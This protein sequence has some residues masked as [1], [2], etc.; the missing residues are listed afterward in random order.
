MDAAVRIEPKS[1]ERHLFRAYI[2][3][4]LGR[5]EEAL[6][7]LGKAI[8]LDPENAD[9]L[10]VRAM[11]QQEE[12]HFDKAEEDYAAAHALQAN[13]SMTTTQKRTLIAGLIQQHFAPE[14]VDNI[15]ITER[16][17]PFRVRADLQRAVEGLFESGT[18]RHFCG[19]MKRYDR[20]GLE[21]AQLITPDQHDP[22]SSAPPQYEEVDVG[23]EEPVRCLKNGL[24]LLADGDA[25]YALMLGQKGFH[26]HV[27]GLR[28][29]LATV[30]SADGTRITQDFFRQLEIAVEKSVSY[31]GK[32]LSL[33]SNDSYFG[34]STG[35]TVHRLK[36]VARDEVILPAGTLE[37]LDRNIIGFC[38]RRGR[39]AEHGLSTKKGILFY[40]P[41]GTGKTHTIHYLAE[42]LEGHTLFLVT[43]EQIGLLD[44]Y[45]NLARLLQPSVLVLEDID[46]IAEDRELPGQHCAQPLLHR[47]L[48]EMDGLR[49]DV[50]V[51]FILTTNRPESLE[52]ALASRPGRIDQAIEFPLPDA[53]GRAKLVRLYAAGLPL[54]DGVVETTVRRTEKVS[55]S[56]IKELMRR[57][58]QF[59]IERDEQAELVALEDVENALEEMLFR[60]GSLNR[61]LLGAD[62]DLE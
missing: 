43:A 18:V 35:I 39:L 45:M 50:E 60:G 27:N 46:L 8:E 19:V 41:P 61:K 32:I 37:L 34:Q 38:R 17:F 52:R 54:A 29:S 7:A 10:A 30:N 20:E 48:N 13:E 62:I 4:E 55:A 3:K 59:R 49:P 51:L 16:V 58:A 6:D 26:G 42:A 11:L 25:R 33:E 31:R 9:A 44:E 28:L 1:S 12:G 21:F 22:A 2:L 47:L 5:T 14:P 40:G 57:A 36:T 23:E 15:T 56:F 24:W 53:E